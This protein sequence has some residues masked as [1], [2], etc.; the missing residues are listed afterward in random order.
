M[1]KLR[2][3]L[4]LRQVALAC[5]ASI[6]FVA[7]EVP[8]CLADQKSTLQA[9]LLEQAP[10][11]LSQLN[12]HGFR[13]V[14][15]LK[16]RVV[17]RPGDVTDSCGAFN[18]RIAEQLEIALALAN[19]PD[20]QRQIKLVHNASRVAHSQKGANHLTADG[21]K[22]LFSATYPLAWGDSEVS[23]DAFVTGVV[24]VEPNMKSIR[25]NILAATPGDVEPK[26]LVRPFV[27]AT[28]ATILSEL[29][30]SFHLRGPGEQDPAQLAR[31]A[32]EQPA[33]RYPLQDRPAVA[34]KIF[35]D[36]KPV[37]QRFGAAHPFYWA[38]FT[39]SAAK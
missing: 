28:D 3:G 7:T 13:R 6:V 36:G 25:V 22:R 16:F 32:Q 35:Y 19:P 10:E 4:T 31:E 34:L 33:E 12:K 17:N 5:L 15:V 9:K 11:I 38:A 23:V 14:G 39:L 30:G 26:V 18:L 2:I 1:N 27:V 24:E 8:N 37:T 29:G 20:A 21:L